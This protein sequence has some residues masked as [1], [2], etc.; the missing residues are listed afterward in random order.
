M[1]GRH[2]DRRQLSSSLWVAH[3]HTCLT[4]DHP[5]LRARCDHVLG[6]LVL[7]P[8]LDIGRGHA[9]VGGSLQLLLKKGL[10]L[11]GHGHLLDL[12]LLDD[13][14]LLLGLDCLVRLAALPHLGRL[15]GLHLALL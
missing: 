4:G 1:T 7:H 13:L 8:L 9:P 6:L 10:A 15:S 14:G 12:D 11:L 3:T 5:V 2:D